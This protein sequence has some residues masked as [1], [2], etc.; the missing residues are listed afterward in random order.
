[1]LLC[2]EALAD[3]E[4]TRKGIAMKNILSIVLFLFMS[5]SAYA[6]TVQ[7]DR[8]DMVEYGIY[9]GTTEKTAVAPGSVSGTYNVV[10][11]RR[12]AVATRSIPAKQGVRFGF[13]YV[14]VGN[15]TGAAIPIRQVWIYPTPG[16]RNPTTQQLYPRSEVAS[17]VTVGVPLVMT[18]TLDNDWEVAPGTWTFQVWY[19]DR[20]LAEQ[21]FT[22]VK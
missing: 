16:V 5:A 9:T 21:T 8:I 4:T 12:L 20:K 6:Q 2:R 11:N 15:P 13:Q 19:E 1:M 18:Y 14:V 22:L 7:I 10:N 3:Q 17:N